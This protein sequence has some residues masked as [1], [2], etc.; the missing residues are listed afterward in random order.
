MINFVIDLFDMPTV[1]AKRSTQ[2]TAAQRKDVPALFALAPHALRCS[3]AQELERH[4][5]D[6]PYFPAWSVFVLRSRTTEL[7]IACGVLVGDSTYADPK[8]VDSAMPCFRLGAFGT[9]GMSTK[10]IKGLFSF[11]CRDDGQCG[12][13]AVE[14][15]SHAAIV[16]QDRDDV[17]ALA[18]QA[19]S[20]VPNLLRFY[21]MNFRRQGAFPVL[22]RSLC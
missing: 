6:N 7:P 10:R 12:S 8:V 16:L 21:Q 5:F 1:P 14:L 2:I 20:D 9:E 19:A 17:V 4:L 3:T 18:A 13:L 22:E 11:L 15:M